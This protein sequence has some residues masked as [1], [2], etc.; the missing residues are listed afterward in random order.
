MT[1]AV[2][3]RFRCFSG[4]K[5]G[6]SLFEW[7]NHLDNTCPQTYCTEA[8]RSVVAPWA[9]SGQA[10]VEIDVRKEEVRAA[11]EVLANY[12]NTRRSVVPQ[13]PGG[14]A[15]AWGWL[16]FAALI[17]LCIAGGGGYEAA[18]VVSGLVCLAS[19]ATYFVLRRRGR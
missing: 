13:Q 14:H 8:W 7:N 3:Q 5:I 4:G 15:R 17:T 11:T 12:R 9:S 18:S 16:A 19:A 10:F 6:L 1:M 2:N